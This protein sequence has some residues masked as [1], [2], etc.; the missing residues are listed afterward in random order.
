[1]QCPPKKEGGALSLLAPV[2]TLM[3]R[4]LVQLLQCCWRQA[5]ERRLAGKEGEE[6]A[7]RTLGSEPNANDGGGLLVP[8]VRSSEEVRGLLG[9]G[10]VRETG[11]V[12]GTD[13][14]E[15]STCSPR[16]HPPFR[17]KLSG[18]NCGCHHGNSQ[19]LMRDAQCLYYRTLVKLVPVF[20]HLNLISSE[21][22]ETRSWRW[23][24][25]GR[26]DLE[27]E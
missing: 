2:V 23:H 6:C 5:G 27:M 15:K 17:P 13:R 20:F 8:A 18:R 25:W 19:Q 14:L 7:A 1:M 9:M 24:G 21:E 11:K 12:R 16:V 26:G 4:W 3:L 22:R 10:E